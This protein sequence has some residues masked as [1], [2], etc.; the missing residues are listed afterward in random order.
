MDVLPNLLWQS[1]QSIYVYQIITLYSLTLHNV[2]CQLYLSKAGNLFLK[3][4]KLMCRV[5][6]SLSSG[7]ALRVTVTS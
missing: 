4:L 2:M 3:E 7:I 1:F 6:Q 5:L